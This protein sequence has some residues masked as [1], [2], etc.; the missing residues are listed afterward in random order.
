MHISLNEKCFRFTP[1]IVSLLLEIEEFKGGWAAHRSLGPVRLANLQRVATMES[2]AS[3]V[4][5][6]GAR[7]T[8]EEVARIMTSY[9]VTPAFASRDEE[10]AAGVAALLH[11]IF[12]AW[13]TMELSESV[14]L[15]MHGTLLK[16]SG[17]DGQHCGRY[18]SVDNAVAAFDDHGRRIGIVLEAATALETPRLM[19]ELVEWTRF[20][21]ELRHLPALI[22]IGMFI[23]F[24]LAVHP[25]EDGNGRLSRALTTLLLLRTGYGFAPYGSLDKEIEATRQSY[26]VC[27]RATQKTLQTADPDWNIWVEYF[28]TSVARQVRRLK[29]KIRDE[30]LLQS[31]P[32]TS[33]RIIELVRSHGPLSISEME[34]MIGISRYT[35]RDHCS[36]LV[37]RNRL[38]RVGAG[39][40]TKYI[41]KWQ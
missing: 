5:I 35:L 24:F 37:H 30:Q 38:Q 36:A 22:V 9:L 27:L 19:R 17:R 33:I 21:L 25:F 28:L 20:H 6:E 12:D 14:I 10:S 7:L 16:T 29:A 34:S 8:D 23:V 4:R 32:E 39:R 18:K 15:E 1:N 2:I 3:S 41:P 40:A 13:E 26:F 31:M 11:Q